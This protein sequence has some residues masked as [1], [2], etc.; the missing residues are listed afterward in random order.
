MQFKLDL[1]GTGQLEL[2]LAIQNKTEIAK[3][4]KQKKGKNYIKCKIQKLKKKEID[5]RCKKFKKLEFKVL[6]KKIVIDI[7]YQNIKYERKKI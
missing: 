4:E 7:S 6:K 3:W 1:T 5:K 2:S